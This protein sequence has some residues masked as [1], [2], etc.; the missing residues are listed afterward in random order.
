MKAMAAA[1][2]SEDRIRLDELLVA[3]GHYATRSRARDAVERGA[4]TVDGAILAKPGQAVPTSSAIRATSWDSTR[5][6]ARSPFRCDCT[7]R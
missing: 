3:R 5:L 2:K 7:T 6:A 1:G 4:V